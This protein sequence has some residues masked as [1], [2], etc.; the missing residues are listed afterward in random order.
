MI[1]FPPQQR[2]P[3]RWQRFRGKLFGARA[4]FIEFLSHHPPPRQ[5]HRVSLLLATSPTCLEP[6]VQL[7][8]DPD[9]LHCAP[10][11][12]ASSISFIVPHVTSPRRFG[13]LQTSSA[14]WFGGEKWRWPSFLPPLFIFDSAHSPPDR[15]PFVSS[16]LSCLLIPGVLVNLATVPVK[17]CHL[18]AGATNPP[19]SLCPSPLHSLS[20]HFA[21][22]DCHHSRAYFSFPLPV[23]MSPAV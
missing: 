3:P 20:L 13:T 1:Y 18:L 2:G 6:T 12:V 16:R 21:V 23:V 15:T 5:S 4:S 7:K 8:T 22:L 14:T 19:P 10:W 9:L 11:P 17:D